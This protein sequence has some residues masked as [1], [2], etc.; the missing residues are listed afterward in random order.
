[1]FTL[2]AVV[3]LVIVN[4]LRIRRILL[5]QCIYVGFEVLIA[6]I[7]KST[8]FWDITPCSKLKVNQHFRGTYRL[9]LQ[10]WRVSK[11][12]YQNQAGSGLTITGIFSVISQ[13]IKLFTGLLY[14]FIH[15]TS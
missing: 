8:I 5:L 4:I 2:C 1:M 15:I 11:A 13:K 3:C 6:V 14:F 10:G 12:R 9:H 7:M